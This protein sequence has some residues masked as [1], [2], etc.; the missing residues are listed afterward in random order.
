M[1]PSPYFRF[2]ATSFPETARQTSP[3]RQLPQH[4]VASGGSKEKSAASNQQFAAHARARLGKAP[5]IC[6][7]IDRRRYWDP[8][9][10]P[11][12][13][14][15]P[16]LSRIQ[17]AKALHASSNSLSLQPFLVPGPLFGDVGTDYLISFCSAASTPRPPAHPSL[18][19][20]F[21][22]PLSCAARCRWIQSLQYRAFDTKRS[23]PSVW[24]S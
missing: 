9:Q 3:L 12:L 1:T 10:L 17:K 16:L 19:N 24:A 21:P 22:A 2:T 4:H 11:T 7:L 5:A 18:S 14:V 13:H 8:F 15:L 23:I 20:P 6:L